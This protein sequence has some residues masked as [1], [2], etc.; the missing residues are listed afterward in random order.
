MKI[1]AII[2]EFNP[3]HNG[4]R[5]LLEQAKMRTGCDAALCLMSGSFTQRGEICLADR[6]TRAKHAVLGGADAVLELPVAFAVAP[7][8]IFAKGAVKILSSLPEVTHLAFGCETDADFLAAAKLL[9]AESQAFRATLKDCLG[10]GE[11]YVKSYACAFA[12]CGGERE[13]LA[14]PNNVLAVEYAKAMLSSNARFTLCPVKRVGGGYSDNQL[15]ADFSSASAIRANLSDPAVA[16][17]VPPY[18]YEQLKDV[19][20]DENN[21]ESILKYALMRA[22]KRDLRRI[23]GCCEGLENALKELAHLPFDDLLARATG[24][25][26]TAARI[27]RILLGNALGLYES[28]CREF[29]EGGLYLKPLAVRGGRRDEIFR[30]LSKS[31][32]P[33][34][35][36]GRDAAALEGAA[37]KCLSLD[38]FAAD[39][40]GV[41]FG[42]TMQSQSAT[43][44]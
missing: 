33:V 2:C 22:D 21:Y 26:Y 15:H 40:R 35:M 1:C 8:E 39:V 25:R 6:F 17:N 11:S 12:A 19:R 43:I 18:V 44:V 7:A 4:H 20:F 24:K 10:R 5:Y 34:I 37:A 23:Y 16:D 9:N 36:N 14:S 3:F 27:R 38:A 28:D 29:L 42:E 31:C 32:Y 41:I 30:A 13:V